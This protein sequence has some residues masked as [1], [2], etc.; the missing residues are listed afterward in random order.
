VRVRWIAMFGI[1]VGWGCYESVAPT[2][3]IDPGALDSGLPITNPPDGG[4]ACVPRK[5]WEGPGVTGVVPIGGTSGLVISGD[6]YFIAELSLQGDASDANLGRITSWHETGLLR[7]L[8]AGAPRVVGVLPWDDPGVT[9]A[10]VDKASGDQIIISRFRRWVYDGTQWP[11]AGNIIDDWIINDAGPIPIEGG[12]AP[13]EGPGVTAGY[14]T[15]GGDLFY[16]ISQNMGWVRDTSDPDPRNWTWTPDGGFMLADSKQWSSAA[17][18]GGQRPYD[19][20][21]VT[22]AYYVGPKLFVIRVDRLWTWDGT[23]WTA[24]GML[25]DAEGWSSA[26][27]AGCP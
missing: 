1:F 27:S 11:A 9:A 14:F 25:K 19:G 6:R 16:A 17:A 10:Y 15:P 18:I 8:W 26:P 24:V 5:P 4:D 7:E 13:W 3:V 20:P 12:R 22:T 21:G 2:A 23:A